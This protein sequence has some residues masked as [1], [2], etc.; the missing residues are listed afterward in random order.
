[1]RPKTTL[2]CP[3]LRSSSGKLAKGAP[4]KTSSMPSPLKSPMSL[5]DCPERSVSRTPS[6]AKPVLILI[7]ATSRVAE[8]GSS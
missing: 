6:M 1:M 5:T 8:N 4:I 2:A 7:S 3:A